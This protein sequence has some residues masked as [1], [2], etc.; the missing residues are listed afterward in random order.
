[1]VRV[2]FILLFVS[3]GTKS[4]GDL[5]LKSEVEWAEA[6]NLQFVQGSGIY[7]DEL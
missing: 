1:M 5:G 2:V 4:V 6:H 3:H 7:A